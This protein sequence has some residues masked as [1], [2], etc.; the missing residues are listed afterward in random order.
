MICRGATFPVTGEEAAAV[1]VEPPRLITVAYLLNMSK[2]LPCLARPIVVAPKVA[3][4]RPVDFALSAGS[5]DSREV[6]CE[7]NWVS[8]SGT[9]TSLR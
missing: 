8:V 6:M 2:D 3:I 4:T 1:G 7:L 5:P 9:N